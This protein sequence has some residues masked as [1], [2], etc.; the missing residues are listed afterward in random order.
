L[1]RIVQEALSNVHRHSG[2]RTAQI[3]LSR[4]L[5][6]IELRV[7][8]A[9]RGLTRDLPLA[10]ETIADLG[11]GIAGMRERARQLGGLLEIIGSEG[12]TTVRAVLPA[13][14]VEESAA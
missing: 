9:G 11:V 1:F 8:D 12:G 13:R 6:Q 3:H 10:N 2:S 4:D 7:A 5:E 14:E